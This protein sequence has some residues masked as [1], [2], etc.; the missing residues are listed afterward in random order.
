MA[1]SVAQKA[2]VREFVLAVKDRVLEPDDPWLVSLAEHGAGDVVDDIATE[3]DL[4]DEQGVCLLTG[5]SGTGKSTALKRLKRRLEE[6]SATV[7]YVD[8]AQVLIT[9]KRVEITDFLLAVAGALSEQVEQTFGSS[10][11]RLGYWDRFTNFMQTR[12]EV[13]ELSA[14]LPGLDIKAALKYDPVF[15]QRLQAA[16]RPHIPMLVDSLR[17]FVSDCVQRVRAVREDDSVKVVLLVDSVER[18]RGVRGEEM[19]VYESVRDLF[20]RYAHYLIIPKLHLVYTVP[21]YLTM[22]AP[23]AA[24]G[25]GATHTRRLT[26]TRVWSKSPKREPDPDGLRCMRS[27][28]DARFCGWNQIFEAAAVNAL[29]LS[30]GGDLRKFLSLVSACLFAGVRDDIPWPMTDGAI[31]HVQLA[32]SNEMAQL[33][34]DHLDWL[35]RIK[36]SNQHC[37]DTE[38]DLPTF[39]RFLD[40]QQ[41]LTYRNGQF[42]YDVHPLLHDLI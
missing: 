31:R 34:R 4:R 39:A 17:D 7:F 10:P 5:Q 30:S 40:N 15:K 37:L 22:L 36:L 19:E 16:A 21:T 2:K 38:A 29:A 27:L 32:A 9:D 41:I 33:P 20:L 8:L 42:W 18:I 25:I 6:L 24:I 35:Q 12:V 3:I 26:S 23:G 1:Y 13:T 14:K 28:L 11:G